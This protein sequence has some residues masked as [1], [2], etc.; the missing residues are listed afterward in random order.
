MCSELKFSCPDAPDG[1]YSTVRC[2][3]GR[4][5]GDRAPLGG[6]YHV[7][8]RAGSIEYRTVEPGTETWTV[9]DALWRRGG[10]RAIS[11][12]RAEGCVAGLIAR[13][14]HGDARRGR[15]L[16]GRGADGSEAGRGAK[17][18]TAGQQTQ[19]ELFE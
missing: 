8:I 13:N 5:S 11:A 1:R 16:T 7:T 10:V 14:G 19:I 17:N 2:R 18:A 6:R 12:S 9:R 3:C 4:F 15:H